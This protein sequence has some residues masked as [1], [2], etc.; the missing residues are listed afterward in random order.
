MKKTV[1]IIF[2]LTLFIT[3]FA[4]KIDYTNPKEYTLEGITISGT[5]SLN[6]GAIV[7]ITGLKIGSKIGI[8][9]D[10][11]SLAI[12]KLWKQKMFSD[13]QIN[14]EKI[15]GSN[16]WLNIHL[17]ERPRLAEINFFGIR[18]SDK[19]DLREQINIMRGQQITENTIVN[20]K[21]II[22]DYYAEKGFSKADVRIVQRADTSLRNA[23]VINISINKF[24]KTRIENIAIK[25]NTVF[26]ERKVKWKLLKETKERR[27]YGL[28][29]PSKYIKENYEEDKRSLIAAYHA[30]GYR[31]AK[32]IKDTI[33]DANDR[34]VTIFIE[35]DEGKQ[36]FFRDIKWIGNSKYSSETLDKL[37]GIKKGDVYNK[38]HLGDRLTNAEDA[39]GNLYMNN[40]FLFFNVNPVEIR[41]DN[42]SVDI[43][44]RM[45]EGEKAKIK[46]IVIIGN[47][48]TNDNVIRREIRTV[49]GE[50]FSKEDIIRTI[51]ELAQLGHF[52]PENIV[53]VPVPNPVDGTV[54]IEYTLVERGNDRVEISGG[55]GAGMLVGTLGLTFNNF[56][57]QNIFEKESWQPLPTGDGQKFSI[58]AQTNGNRYQSYS[59]SFVEPWLGGKKPNSLSVSSYY[60]RQTYGSGGYNP[61]GSAF[62]GEATEY[63][64][65]SSMNVLGASAGFGRRNKWPDDYFSQY[66]ELGYQ[67]YILNNWP[68]FGKDFEN[69]TANNL[70]GKFILS[71]NSVSQP[72]YPRN[73]SSFSLGVEAT[74]PYSKFNGKDYSNL[75]TE[76]KY[77][78]LEYH[79]WTFKASW[80]SQIVGDLVLNTKM[81]FG[82]LAY[83]NSEVGYSPFGGYK[84]GGSGMGYYSYGTDIVGLRGYEDGKLGSGYIYD[85][86]TLEMRYPA[87]FSESATVYGLVFLEAGNVWNNNSEVNPFNIY[88]S[89]GAGIRVFLPMLGLLGVDWGYGFDRLPGS[90]SVSGTQFHFVMGQQF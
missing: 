39:V 7:R 75:S 65:T 68:S 20:T 77:K 80:F 73:G 21:N 45:Y 71:R 56:S 16:V 3:G 81:E 60:N 30:E 87:I 86:Y 52:D 27:W 89:A 48:R 90:S 24:K 22:Q 67:K 33:Y 44:L 84:V 43:E 85:K 55:W 42:D 78:W 88:K 74:L 47:T 54:D 49:P 12:K 36:Y 53:P 11:I 2:L 82:M 8:P 62:S 25:G 14:I 59:I 57:I 50:L 15:E 13:V 9:G 6:H 34:N 4:Q 17:Q 70:T 18:K 40:G 23:V 26:T 69:G 31:D 76:E 37:L 32:I 83:Y 72:L 61:Y 64:V 38:A 58:R 1:G 46:N 5:E 41:M 19:E 66:F 29:K 63:V 79:K 10:E 51:R 35:V 28:F